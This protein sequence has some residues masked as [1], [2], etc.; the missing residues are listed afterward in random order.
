MDETGKSAVTDMETVPIS[1]TAKSIK[2]HAS[3]KTATEE[4]GPAAST[5]E[6][7]EDSLSVSIPTIGDMM[8]SGGSLS[9]LALVASTNLQG[10]TASDE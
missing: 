3:V 2:P 8:I 7:S 9:E 1:K 6:S 5:P 4:D 10:R